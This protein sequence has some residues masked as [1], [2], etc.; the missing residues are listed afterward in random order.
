MFNAYETYIAVV[1]AGSLSGAARKLGLSPAMVSKRIAH[2][3]DRLGV[4][5]ME[6]T[7][8]R[9]ALTDV[10][11]QFYD[12]IMPAL[13][14]VRE[15]E[16]L[17]S[18]RAVPSRGVLRVS[19][20]TSFARLHL[21]PHLKGF[22]D[23]HPGLTL[24]LHLSDSFVDLAAE[25]IDVAI[26]IGVVDEASAQN[27]VW[28]APNQRIL[29]AAPG[30][31]REHG[32]PETLAELRRHRLLAGSNQSTWRLVG[33]DG[34]ELLRVK[35]FLRTN[36]SDLVRELVLSG[37]GIALRSYWDVSQDLESGALETVLERYQGS[38]NVGL[39]A[40][41]LGQRNASPGVRAFV[42]FLSKLYG[43]S[44]YWMPRAEAA[45]PA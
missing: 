14:A 35:S 30:Y 21:A 27:A 31:L 10:G 33:P 32:R 23:L 2:L 42:E 5:L 26:R 40:L 15:A 6:R 17:A 41:K 13:E 8:R 1:D 29:C 34:P 37:L 22:L 19:A 12:Q 9:M 28:L 11:R 25:G 3:E 4:R 38:A 39:Y 45:P 44:P 18:G 16:A 36:S 7:T 24:D 43:Q 20:P